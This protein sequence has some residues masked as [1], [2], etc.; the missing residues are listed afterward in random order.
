MN[1]EGRTHLFGPDINTD[2][3][4][5][6]EHKAVM[7]MNQMARHL[8]ESIRPGFYDQIKRGDIL[9]AGRNFGGGSSREAAPRVI[10]TAGLAGVLAPSFARIFFRNA[11][12]IGLPV[13]ETPIDGIRDGD[14]LRVDFLAGR[15]TNVTAGTDWTVKPMP[16]FMMG[17]VKAGGI[18]EYMRRY[19]SFQ[20]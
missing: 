15:I 16:A 19:G 20:L 4:I 13:L 3:I 17:I 11:V 12:N 1:A 8:M 5:S 6:A 9:V 18:V 2:Y 7:D 10:K 14:I